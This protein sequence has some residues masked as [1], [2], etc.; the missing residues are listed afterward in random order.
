M[1]YLFC[2]FRKADHSS[3][4]LCQE[5]GENR[6]ARYRAG[7]KANEAVC[8]RRLTMDYKKHL[9]EKMKDRNFKKEYE[10]LEP[11]FELLK[12]LLRLREMRHVSQKELASRVATKQPNIARFERE[13]FK[14][15]TLP[16]L[17]KIADALDARLIIKF[18]P[19][20]SKA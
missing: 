9:A 3:S 6:S 20:K 16:L 8:G 12:S 17:K 13:G 15:A 19:R 10:A 18:E 4:W 5:N 2:R 1:Y 14:R 7:R 11:E